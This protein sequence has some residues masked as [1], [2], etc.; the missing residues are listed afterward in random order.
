[1][2]ESGLDL[3]ELLEFVVEFVVALLDDFGLEVEFIVWR[4][5][6]KAGWDEA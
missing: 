5:V 2:A 3:L 1:M 4:P 6:L